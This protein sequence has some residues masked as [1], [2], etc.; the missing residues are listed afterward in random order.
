MLRARAGN[1]SC[2]ALPYQERP[3]SAQTK[4]GKRTD[5]NSVALP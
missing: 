2:I 5:A 3:Q 1:L 4:H